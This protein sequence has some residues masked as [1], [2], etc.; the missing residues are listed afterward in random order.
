MNIIQ[1]IPRSA[2]DPQ[3]IRR[4]PPGA[5]VIL[6]RAENGRTTRLPCNRT[7]VARRPGRAK[8]LL[9]DASILLPGDIVLAVN[10]SRPE[11]AR[12]VAGWLRGSQP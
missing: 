12:W 10:L 8:L 2:S 3:R 4:R 7:I 1:K 5:D 6:E 9:G 11:A